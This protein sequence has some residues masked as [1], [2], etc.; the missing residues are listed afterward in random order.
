[1]DKKRVALIVQSVLWVMTAIVFIASAVSIYVSGMNLKAED[2]MADIYGLEAIR[3]RAVIALP[4]L[5]IC[6][7]NS[8]LLAV[9]GIK[10]ENADKAALH[11]DIAKNTEGSSWPK[12]K[13]RTAR[14]AGIALAVICIILGMIN[15]SMLDVLIK[16]SK[17]CTE[18]IGLG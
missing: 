13:I 17:I 7:A 8:V 5:G 18:C 1:M 3:Q 4:L 6:I 15:G 16:A 10:D 12:D 9:L 2:P 14:M 11:V